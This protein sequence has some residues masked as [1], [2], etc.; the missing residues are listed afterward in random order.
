MSLSPSFERLSRPG[1]WSWLKAHLADSVLELRYA[2]GA[3]REQVQSKVDVI[4]DK[5]AELRALL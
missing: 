3:H 1:Q 5:M 2:T 4:L